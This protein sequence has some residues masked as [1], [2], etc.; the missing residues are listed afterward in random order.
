LFEELIGSIVVFTG[1]TIFSTFVILIVLISVFIVFRL[2]S[3]VSIFVNS[4][5]AVA[6]AVPTVACDDVTPV[7]A[8]STVVVNALYADLSALTC[9]FKLVNIELLRLLLLSIELISES[10][11]VES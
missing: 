5:A 6:F 3:T 1:V 8:V 2:V 10:I 7:V 9:V 4:F 11:P